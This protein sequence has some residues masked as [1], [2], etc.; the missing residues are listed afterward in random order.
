MFICG[1]NWVGGENACSLTPTSV[2]KINYIEIGNGMY[3]YLY[4]AQDITQ[5][6]TQNDTPADTQNNSLTLDMCPPEGWDTHTL[7][8][9]Q[10]NGN[11]NAGNI[12][13]NV[14]ETSHLIVKSRAKNSFT[15]KTLS[16]KEV[17]SAEDFHIYYNDYFVPSGQET[18]YAIVPVYYGLEG[19]Y[20]VSTITPRFDRM[21]LIEKDVVYGTFVTDG[22]C[23]TTRNIPSGT[24]QLLN[25]KYPIFVKNTIANYD[26]GT[27]SGSFIN[28]DNCEI[29]IG[30]QS[31]Y[32]TTKYQKEV[33]DFLCDGHPKIL[34]MPDGRT[35]LVQVTPSPTDTANIRYNNRYF[36]FSWVEIGDVNSEE[37]LYYLGLSD[38]SPEWWNLS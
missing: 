35:W 33:M 2:E 14:S 22:F 28:M 24:V 1:K 16:V 38:V 11:T 18:E 12:D 30:Q 10:F 5:D 25:S 19:T 7:L 4:L 36:S 3:D 21:F 23:D 37:D 20:S 13:K 17:H 6:D 15:W 29:S 34:K 9:A 26:T 27:C 8:Y 32:L 31:D